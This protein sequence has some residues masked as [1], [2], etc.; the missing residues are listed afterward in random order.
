MLLRGF[1]EV[2]EEDVGRS[3]RVDEEG[4]C[5][6]DVSDLWKLGVQPSSEVMRL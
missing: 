4:A 1:G 2:V 6:F 5:L 3:G